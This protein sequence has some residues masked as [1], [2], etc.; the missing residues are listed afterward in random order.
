MRRRILAGAMLGAA[1]G[2]ATPRMAPPAD[3]VEATESLTTTGRKRA[4]GAL[5]NE[6]FRLG[7]YD[8]TNVDRKSEKSRSVGVGPWS[9]DTKTNGFTYEL[10]AGELELSG[11]CAAKS[12]S[13]GIGS[14]SGSVSWGSLEMACSCEDDDGKAEL[15]MT[16]DERWLKVVGE[17]YTLEPIYA[18]E[19]GKKSSN[20]SGFRA[21]N[22]D[23]E[24][25]GAVEVVYPGQVWVKKGIDEAKKARIACV[26]AGLML[27]Q[28]P[29]DD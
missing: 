13:Q 16:D 1:G 28:P 6:S 18:L 23:K 5:V 2:C 11:K 22:P 19:G 20:P 10:V 27:Y 25:L 12:S 14:A 15:A 4:S 3:V 8:V 26:F 29:S 9:K 24:V 7:D 21:D 17:E